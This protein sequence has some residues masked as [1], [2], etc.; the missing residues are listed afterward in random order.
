MDEIKICNI[1]SFSFLIAKCKGVFPSSSTVITDAPS[2]RMRRK[3]KKEKSKRRR[4]VK[5]K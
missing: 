4:N 2:R 1:F 3:S 5:R